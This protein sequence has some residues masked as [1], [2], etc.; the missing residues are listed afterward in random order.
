MK[1]QGPITRSLDD[2]GLELIALDGALERLREAEKITRRAA[3]GMI[4]AHA[5]LMAHVDQA[6]VTLEFVRCRRALN[7]SAAGAIN[8]SQATRESVTELEAIA[9]EVRRAVDEIRGMHPRVTKV[10]A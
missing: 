7:T 10:P 1:Q 4:D 5:G 2:I 8:A 6:D 9:D 3:T